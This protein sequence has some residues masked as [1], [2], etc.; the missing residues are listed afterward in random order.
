MGRV[1]GDVHVKVFF[2]YCETCKGSGISRA[3]AGDD[4]CDGLCG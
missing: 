3:E 1:P 4:D 2:G